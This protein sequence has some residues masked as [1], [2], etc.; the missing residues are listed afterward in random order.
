VLF[1]VKWQIVLP[2]CARDELRPDRPVGRI[3]R[4]LERQSK[5]S[6]QPHQALGEDVA[7]HGGFR[8]LLEPEVQ[9]DALD[10]FATTQGAHRAPMAAEEDHGLLDLA[11]EIGDGSAAHRDVEAR[12]EAFP[13]ARESRESRFGSAVNRNGDERAPSEIGVHVKV[14]ARNPQDTAHS[15]SPLVDDAASARR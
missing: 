1:D 11:V 2:R 9:G 4:H 8:T 7:L 12:F 13:C 10:S 15:S 5:L 3:E 6:G 14:L